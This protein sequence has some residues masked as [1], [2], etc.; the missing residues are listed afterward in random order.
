ML[1]ESFAL[2]SEHRTMRCFL[3]EVSVALS[4]FKCGS[5]TSIQ[6]YLSTVV[7]EENETHRKIAHL[8]LS[9]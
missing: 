4:L 9:V 6:P 1:L 5:S 7:G 2:C 3:S 8:L